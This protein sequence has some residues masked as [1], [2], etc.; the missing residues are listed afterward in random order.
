MELSQDTKNKTLDKKKTLAEKGKI[1]FEYALIF[2]YS[3]RNK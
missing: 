2:R 3:K 1:F